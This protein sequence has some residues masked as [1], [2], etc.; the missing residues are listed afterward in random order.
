MR[1]GVHVGKPECKIDAVTGRMD[2]VGGMVNRAAR[3][4][5]M[6]KWERD[7]ERGCSYNMTLCYGHIR[8]HIPHIGIASGGQVFL[9]GK[10]WE[11]ARREID[12]VYV[13]HL[14]QQ[15][16]KGLSS[17]E[18]IVQI[19]PKSVIA[20]CN[21]FPSPLFPISFSISFSLFL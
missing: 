11:G 3:I 12:N 18:Q 2:Y 7:R 10:A 9:S 6:N 5:G 15:Y 20:V 21:V 16:L 4:T 14:G 19:L 17:A 8:N 1:M 13:E